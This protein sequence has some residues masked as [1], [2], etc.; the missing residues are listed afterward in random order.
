M[1][2]KGMNI[3]LLFIFVGSPKPQKKHFVV[4]EVPLGSFGWEIFMFKIERE[5][6][7]LRLEFNWE[8]RFSRRNQL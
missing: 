4:E 7:L 1:N 6:Y 5:E 3:G 2:M 8:T